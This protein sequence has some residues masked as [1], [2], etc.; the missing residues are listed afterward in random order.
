M[1]G[2]VTATPTQGAQSAPQSVRG[3]PGSRTPLHSTYAVLGAFVHNAY[4][5]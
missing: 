1:E 5:S 3:L 4:A 2:Q